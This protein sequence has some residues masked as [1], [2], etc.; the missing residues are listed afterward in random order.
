MLIGFVLNGLRS[1]NFAQYKPVLILV[2]I[3][4]MT[5]TCLSMYWATRSH[6]IKDEKYKR[7]QTIEEALHDVMGQ[8]TVRAGTG[9]WWRWPLFLVPFVL[10]AVVWV[11]LLVDVSRA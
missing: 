3:T 1:S 4:G 11:V 8:H 7:C 2:V 9:K 5:L 10:L 6:R